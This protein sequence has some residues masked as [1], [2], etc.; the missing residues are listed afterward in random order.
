MVDTPVVTVSAKTGLHA[1]KI[2]PAARRVYEA[3][4]VRIA[5]SE[6]NGWLAE[7][8]RRREPSIAKRARGQK[9][10]IKLFYATQTAVHPP[11][12]AIVCT[13]PMAIQTS[14]K[15]FLENRLREAY[16]FDGT[17]IRLRLR[18]RGEGA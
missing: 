11:T 3:A 1:P 14:Y 8:L 9:R 18:A 16:G 7:T 17:P 15:R 4:G 5:T 6:L 12:F 13:D 2:L 10:P